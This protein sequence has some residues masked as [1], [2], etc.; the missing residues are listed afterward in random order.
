[1]ERQSFKYP[2]AQ[3]ARLDS[4]VDD[5]EYPHRAEAIRAAIRTFL[6]GDRRTRPTH[7]AE[8]LPRL[9]DGQTKET[10]RLPAAQLATLDD[11][12]PDEY[13]SVSEAIRA[14]IR[15]LLGDPAPQPV[16]YADGGQR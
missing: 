12:V 16:A 8:N 13:P 7:R 14:A 11:L 1:M 15:E 6:A 10:V 9:T 4:L 5:G 3:Q 2:P